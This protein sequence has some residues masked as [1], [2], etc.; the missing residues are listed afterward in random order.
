MTLAVSVNCPGRLWSPP[1]L[2]AQGVPRVLSRGIKQPGG[3]D[4]QSFPS[5]AGVTNA[6][7]Y[8]KYAPLIPSWRV[9]RQFHFH[10][11]GDSYSTSD[12][13]G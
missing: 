9:Q 12:F 7:G 3:E 2:N 4:N 1:S 6:C 8:T 10:Q 11:T 5:I 13:N